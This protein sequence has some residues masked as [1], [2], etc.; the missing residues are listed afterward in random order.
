M[1]WVNVDIPWRMWKLHREDCRHSKPRASRYKGV[2]V[3]ERDGGWF[4]FPTVEEAYEYYKEKGEGDI[5][6]PCKFC[7]PATS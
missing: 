5:W 6:Q 3:M 2:N 1:F 4:K 7:K